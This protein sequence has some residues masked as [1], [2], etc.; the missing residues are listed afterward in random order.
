[1]ERMK[2]NPTKTVFLLGLPDY[3]LIGPVCMC[4]F[5]CVCVGGLRTFAFTFSVVQQV[6]RAVRC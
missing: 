5:M 2:K 6:Q 4:V 3:C 1:M